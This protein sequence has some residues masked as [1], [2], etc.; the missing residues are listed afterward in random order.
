MHM[1]GIRKPVTT[2]VRKDNARNRKSRGSPAF[3]SGK[4]AA[5]ATKKGPLGY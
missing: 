1:Q 4:L 5:T 3:N 2:V